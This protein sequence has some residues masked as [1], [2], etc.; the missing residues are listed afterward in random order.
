A[1]QQV[2]KYV[3]DQMWLFNPISRFWYSL[4]EKKDIFSTLVQGSGV[5]C[6]D[7]WVAHVLAD[8]EQLTAQFHDEIV[9]VVKKGFS[10]YN[11]ETKQ[12]EGPIVDWLKQTIKE[13]NDFLKLNRK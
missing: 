2:V 12:W 9:L 5:Y 8:R 6:F 1:D 7:T 10:N 13:T 4:R 11:K 3:R